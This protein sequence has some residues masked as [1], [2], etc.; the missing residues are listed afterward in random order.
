MKGFIE[1]HGYFD[2]YFRDTEPILINVSKINA[3][4]RERHHTTSLYN[5]VN[6]TTIFIC[7]TTYRVKEDY[8]TVLNMI[9]EAMSGNAESAEEDENE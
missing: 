5:Y 6:I 2:G 1:L 9:E 4:Y 8:R 7:N 3:V